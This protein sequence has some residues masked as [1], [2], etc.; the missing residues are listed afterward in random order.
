MATGFHKEDGNNPLREV[1][2]GKQVFIREG[3]TK[4]RDKSLFIR[5]KCREPAFNIKKTEL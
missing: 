5:G 3:D 1:S 4:K 2:Y